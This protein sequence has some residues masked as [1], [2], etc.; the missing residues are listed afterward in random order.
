MNDRERLLK[1]IKKGRRSKWWQRKGSRSR[2]FYYVNADGK[3]ITDENVVERIKTLVIP[4]AWK[5]V[6]ISPTVGSRIQ[7]VGADT[8]GRIQ[9]IYNPKFAAIQARRKFAKIEEFAA[10]LP[11]LRQT[12]NEHIA[13]AGFPRDKVLA[14]MIR[15]INSLYIRMGSE[16]SVRR[17]KTFGI[18][19][20]Q[21]RHLEIKRGG[22]LVF[23]FVGKGSIKHRQI[24][25]DNELAQL[26]K[27]LQALG[28]SRKLFHYVDAEADARPVTPSDINGYIKSATGPQFSA[29]DFRT[30]GASVQAA[31]ELAAQGVAESET[32]QKRNIVTAVKRT[33]EKLGNTPTVCRGSY[34]HPTVI[35]AYCDGVLIDHFRPRTSR[36]SSRIAAELEPEEAALLRLLE[37]YRR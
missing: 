28:T 9:Y 25:V 19:T 13:L 30:W 7:A 12:T 22:R 32:E 14:I 10:Y 29:K 17:Y 16:Q 5:H 15:L 37:R 6:R 24:L 8:S 3:K 36:R 18:T 33:A 11:K 21:N 26:M 4:P 34:I 1:T 23:N 35:D 2:G 20:L 27:D 31:I